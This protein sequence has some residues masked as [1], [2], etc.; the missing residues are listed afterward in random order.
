M[1]KTEPFFLAKKKMAPQL[2]L[3]Q[4]RNLARRKMPS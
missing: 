1:K 3:L 2:T 4:I